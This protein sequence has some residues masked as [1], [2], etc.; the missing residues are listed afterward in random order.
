MQEEEFKILKNSHNIHWWYRGRQKIIWIFRKYLKKNKLHIADAGAGY[1]SNITFLKNYGKITALE[2]NKNAIKHLEKTFSN[3]DI[4][5]WKSPE[6][7][8]IKFDLIVFADVLEH[9]KDDIKA[10]KWTKIIYTLFKTTNS[11]SF[12]FSF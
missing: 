2:S 6:K 5:E 12:N 8:S 3:I 11:K 10:L 4:L 9:I 1:G 7:I